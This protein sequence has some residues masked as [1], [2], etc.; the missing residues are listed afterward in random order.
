MGCFWKWVPKVVYDFNKCLSSC[1]ETSKP[2]KKRK[3]QGKLISDFSS[4][5]GFMLFSR[6][7][8][9]FHIFNSELCC[10]QQETDVTS[11]HAFLFGFLSLYHLMEQHERRKIY[12]KWHRRETD[13]P[14]QSIQR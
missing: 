10:V 1:T 8:I 13:C 12:F 4:Y 5:C 6:E 7:I 2:R 3:G 14:Q 9:L 11:C